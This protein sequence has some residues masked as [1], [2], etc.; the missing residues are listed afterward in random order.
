M[1]DRGEISNMVNKN[2]IFN[3]TIF[4]EILLVLQNSLLGLRNDV[5]GKSLKTIKNIVGLIK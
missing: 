5:S 4:D 3:W 2:G 1:L